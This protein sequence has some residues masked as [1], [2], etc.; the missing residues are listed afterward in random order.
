M[1]PPDPD[2]TPSIETP[3]MRCALPNGEGLQVGCGLRA[4]G[5]LEQLDGVY[6]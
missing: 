6:V 1:T 2:N 5:R 3:P 4:A